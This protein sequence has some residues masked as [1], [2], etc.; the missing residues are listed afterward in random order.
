[1]N[2]DEVTEVRGDTIYYDAQKT[3]APT[4][5]FGSNNNTGDAEDGD[6]VILVDRFH[7]AQAN[8]VTDFSYR[9]PPHGH[10][11]STKKRA[12]MTTTKAQNASCIRSYEDTTEVGVQ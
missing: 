10:V 12:R 7:V 5:T 4:A 11:K 2:H 1:M 6:V 8:G 9:G 3:I